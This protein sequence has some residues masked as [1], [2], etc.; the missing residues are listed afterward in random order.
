M[1]VLVAGFAPWGKIRRNSSG[2]VA[3]ALGGSVLPVRYREAGLAIARLIRAGRP[4]AILLLGLA[5]GRKKI[6]LE[7]VAMNVDHCEDR[8]WKRWQK[9]IMRGPF[10]LRARLPIDRIHRRLKAAGF[11][12]SVSHHAGTFVCNHVFYVAL[13]RS[14]VPCGFVHLPPPGVLSQR[15]QVHAV[16][17]ILDVIGAGGAGRDKAPYNNV[18]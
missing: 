9:R 2:H 1:K 18:R 7:A 12:V 16:R 11:P 6:C 8:P 10:T 5:P 3:R 17:L 15:R 13:A 4:R 14:S